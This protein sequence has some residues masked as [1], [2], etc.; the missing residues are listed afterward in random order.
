MSDFQNTCNLERKEDLIIQMVDFIE[1]PGLG[2]FLSAFHTLC[3]GL[4]ST[5]TRYA[6]YQNYNVEVSIHMKELSTE[7]EG[8]V[9]VT[10]NLMHKKKIYASKKFTI[11]KESVPNFM[12]NYSGERSFMWEE[13][14]SQ[15][16]STNIK[17]TIGVGI[18]KLFYSRDQPNVW[19]GRQVPNRTGNVRVQNITPVSGT[20]DIEKRAYI[21]YENAK[22]VLKSLRKYGGRKKEELAGNVEIY[23]SKD[24]AL[25]RGTNPNGS[26]RSV[27]VGPVG[28]TR[29]KEEIHSPLDE[30][31]IVGICLDY[32]SINSKFLGTRGIWPRLLNSLNSVTNSSGIPHNGP[33]IIG[34]PFTWPITIGVSNH[35]NAF[36]EINGTTVY[37]G[38]ET[39]QVNIPDDLDFSQVKPK[40]VNK[41]KKEVAKVKPAT[42]I[43]LELTE[44]QEPYRDAIRVWAKAHRIECDR[45]GKT[46]SKDIKKW[47]TSYMME[48]ARAGKPVPPD[49]VEIYNQVK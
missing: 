41:K 11:S 15:D 29:S 6:Y 10:V 40:K 26:L 49:Q 19:R 28:S 39:V 1:L 45:T 8:P 37:L 17:D 44:A 4:D 24:S 33:G 3:F 27:G 48:R 2:N 42:N 12:K 32:E 23:F 7:P 38:T 46:Y 14:I 22:T 35:G 5:N 25:M 31:E 30:D 9:E 43:L 18:D 36:I 20:Y 13:Q 16:A 34:E 21:V 47:F